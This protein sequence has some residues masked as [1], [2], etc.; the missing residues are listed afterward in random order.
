[1]SR[2]SKKDKTGCWL[3]PRRI[4]SFEHQESANDLAD[5]LGQGIAIKGQHT[6]CGQCGRIGVQVVMDLPCLGRD[7]LPIMFPDIAGVGG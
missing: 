4:S 2:T 6:D 5:R 1:M 3:Q 7:W